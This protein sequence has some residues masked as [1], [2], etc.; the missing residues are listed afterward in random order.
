M[1]QGPIHQPPPA[2]GRPPNELS[3]GGVNNYRW[4]HGG[5][6]CQGCGGLAVNFQGELASPGTSHTQ[7]QDPGLHHHA[8]LNHAVLPVV[9]DYRPNGVGTKGPAGGQQGYALENAGFTAAVGARNDI[10]T[11]GKFDALRGKVPH[12]FY[13]EA[14]KPWAMVVAGHPGLGL[15]GAPGV[16]QSRIGIT[17]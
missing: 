11:G 1:E 5:E 7:G 17:T 3:G 16:V 9:L 15:T 14:L 8:G 6:L 13:I 2:L 12:P 4:Q 10:A